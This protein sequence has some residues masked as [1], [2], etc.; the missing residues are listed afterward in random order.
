MGL[1]AAGGKLNTY[2]GDGAAI[3]HANTLFQANRA[4]HWTGGGAPT[5]IHSCDRFGGYQYV[6]AEYSGGATRHHYLDDPGAWVTATAYAVGAFRRPSTANG[7]RY[8]VTAIAGSG[9][10]G[11]AE[12]TWPT[13]IGATVVDNAGA[14]QITWTCRT[15]AVTDT[16]CP[17]TKQVTKRQEKMYAADETDVAYCKTG[18]PRDWTAANDAGFIPAG[19]QATG[20]DTVTA[21][22]QFGPHLAIL[23]ADSAQIWS[24]DPDPA[25][26]S[27]TSNIENVGTL[28]HRV[29]RAVG[30]DLFILS[31][32]GFRSLAVLLLTNNAQDQDVGSPIDDLVQ[33]AFDSDDDPMGVYYPKL[34]Q[35]WCV[36]GTQAFVYSFSRTA[37][38]SAWAKFTFDVAFDDMTVLNGELYVRRGNSVYKVTHDV[39]KDG[40]SYVPPVRVE[41]YFQDANKP[42]VLKQFTGV[43]AIGTGRWTISHRFAADDQTLESAAYE[44]PAVSEPGVMYPVELCA[45]RI[46]PILTHER[47]E[48]ARLSL[49]TLYYEALGLV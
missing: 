21:L 19:R 33:A 35:F 26:N 12:P 24:V 4:P 6:V 43:D 25:L 8:E 14:N 48:D 23:F 17:H 1:K 2:Y 5:K 36:N 27:L 22:G 9:T 47:D 41:F 49:L 29:A 30:G 42:G 34:G 32:A 18:D 3:T 16:N 39:T 28:F 13:T 46:A 7:F 37:K 38:L 20:S 44:M 10:S 11:A 45:T 40:A 15:F 31:Q